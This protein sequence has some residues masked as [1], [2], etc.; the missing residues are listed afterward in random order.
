MR[1][2]EKVSSHPTHSSFLVITILVVDPA[3]G[4][5]LPINVS[6]E[7]C[8]RGYTV[9]EGGYWNSESQT[10]ET[11]DNDGYLHTG[12][13]AVINERGL[14]RIDGRIKD[15]GKGGLSRGTLWVIGHKQ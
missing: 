12:D 15:I 9:M 7:L 3:T 1:T 11:I 6:G 8:T 5:T 13:T 14:C 10:K 4:E 2:Q